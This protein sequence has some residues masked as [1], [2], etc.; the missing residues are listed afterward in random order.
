MELQYV[1]LILAA[2]MLLSQQSIRK[3]PVWCNST[4]IGS[5]QATALEL[6]KIKEKNNPSHAISW[7]TQ[8]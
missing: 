6:G 3:V 2:A 8:N 5:N 7:A 4:D 1:F